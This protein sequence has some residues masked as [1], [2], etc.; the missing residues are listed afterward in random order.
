[1]YYY[2]E[3]N[4][5]DICVGV[6]ESLT[7]RT[8]SNLVQV[9]SLNA[10]LI[11]LLYNRTTDNW[12][13]PSFSDLA[14]HSSDEINYRETNESLSDVLDEKAEANHTHAGFA[15]AGHTHEIAG[16]TGL[17]DA[18]D[19]KA[20]AGHTHTQ[21]APMEHDHAVVDVTGLQ[22]ALGA[23]ANDI[24]VVH[25]TGDEAVAG[26]KT[27]SST[28]S[29][30]VSGNA[31]TAT[32]LANARTIGLSGDVSGSGSFDGS[33]NL[34]ITAT[35]AD[36][37]HNHV[38]SNIDG[39]QTAL[40]SKAG[41]SHTHDYLPLTGGQMTAT[42]AMARNVNT[43]FLGLHGGTGTNND[44]AQ[45]YLCG[46]NHPDMAGAFQLHA[47]NSST[48]KMLLGKLDGNLEWDGRHVLCNAFS[49]PSNT[50]GINLNSGTDYESGAYVRL[51]GKESTESAGNFVVA[52]SNGTAI[53]K[54]EGNVDG[55]LVWDGK[56]VITEAGG[57]L[58]GTLTRN[59]LLANTTASSQ[60][61]WMTA[62]TSVSEGASLYL[63]GSTSKNTGA[64]KLRAHDGTNYKD[65]NGNADGTLTWAGKAV[66]LAGHTHSYLPLSGGTCSGTIY[67]PAFQIS[68]DRRLK[69]DIKTIDGALDKIE[70]LSGY[71][72][73]LQGMDA[74]QAGVIAQEV[75]QVLPEAVTENDGIKTVN[76]AAL[77]GLLINAVKELR[78]EIYTLKQYG[79]S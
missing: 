9:T 25:L 10:N 57:K 79:D 32:K 5:K 37:S 41:S 47:R 38:I 45:L 14:A 55:S 13:T 34:T 18:L 33:G 78:T 54:L 58:E 7:V 4:E 75:E 59:G 30:S 70:T 62:G 8:D 22:T 51:Y 46:A 72:Y 67:A 56:D 77:V 11:G 68:S 63:Y 35:V 69:S 1:M 48:T 52:A 12:E 43:S 71:T 64:F 50:S 36:D 65:L 21:Y 16:V 42:V 44:G 61:I 27:F 17:S 31:G 40:D 24:A 15:P 29:G 19:G 2:A 28:I 6:F 20:A 49:M 73:L 76:Y 26:T 60:S 74:R 39:L 66:S 3:L 53:K 23:K